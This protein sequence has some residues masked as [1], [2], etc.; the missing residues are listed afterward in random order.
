MRVASITD[1]PDN[2]YRL[3]YKIRNSGLRPTTTRANLIQAVD[4]DT[5]IDL[6]DTIYEFDSR[7]LVEFFTEMRK[8]KPEDDGSSD[9]LLERLTTS[10]IL[11]RK[12]FR[13]WERH[14]RKLGVQ[15]LPVHQTPIRETPSVPEAAEDVGLL[16]IQR[17]E[18]PPRVEE[19]SHLS[20]TTPTPHDPVLDN[21]TE[22]ETILSMASTDFD[23]DGKGIGSPNLLRR[24]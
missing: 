18:L 15:I 8:G 3:S 21:R 6:F 17:L 16:Q 5:G 11:R 14:A 12:Q 22:R 7:H 23:A 20:E 13:Y 9:A 4:N 1:I 2:L 24:H 19:Q 10:N